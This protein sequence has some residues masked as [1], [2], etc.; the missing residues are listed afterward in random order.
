MNSHRDG[1]AIVV[2]DEGVGT[3]LEKLFC[4]QKLASLH[5]N[6][7][8]RFAMIIFD[9]CNVST[10]SA[11]TVNRSPGTQLIALSW[12]TWQSLVGCFKEHLEDC[13]VGVGH[14]KMYRIRHIQSSEL[15]RA[16]TCL[17]K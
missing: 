15:I 2:L 1:V 11:M 8:G 14:S 7:Q 5:G 10:V 12:R 3:R 17:E 13:E 6:E 4:K 16:S 9:I